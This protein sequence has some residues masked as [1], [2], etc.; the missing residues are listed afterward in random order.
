MMAIFDIKSLSIHKYIDIHSKKTDRFEV[1]AKMFFCDKIKPEN[2]KFFDEIMN[3]VIEDKKFS[4]L[5]KTYDFTKTSFSYNKE[6]F[7]INKKIEVQC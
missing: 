1:L 2:E 5:S 7:F 3:E 4:G 6:K